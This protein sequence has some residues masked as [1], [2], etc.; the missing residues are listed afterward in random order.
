LGGERITREMA[1]KLA[2]EMGLEVRP[3]VQLDLLVLADPDT[4]SIKARRRQCRVQIM[5]EMAFGRAS[6]GVE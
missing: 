2:A 3:S 1:G 4:Q 5:A 6:V